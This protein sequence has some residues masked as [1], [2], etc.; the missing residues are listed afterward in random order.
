MMAEL[1]RATHDDLAAL[2][3]L[4]QAMHL[5]SPRFS[6]YPFLPER[7]HQ[8]MATVLDFEH[9]FVVV[10]EVEGRLMGAFAGLASP[11]FA[12]DVLQAQDIG[13]FI[14]PEHR[15]GTLA[16]RLVRSFLEWARSINAEPTIGINTGVAPERTA[17]LLTA[18][19]AKQSGTN[20]TW[21]I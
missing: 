9:G 14:A 18:L 20:W 13:L 11:H 15:G 19:G 6:I 3:A 5:E 17:Q 4:A 1:R 8:T 2:V 12:C 7:F 16:A 21:G 10:A